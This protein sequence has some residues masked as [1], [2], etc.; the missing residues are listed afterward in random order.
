MSG[1]Q[2]PL[3]GTQRRPFVVARAGQALRPGIVHDPSDAKTALQGNPAHFR[4]CSSGVKSASITPCRC[5]P[6]PLV[7]LALPA[8]CARPRG[9]DVVE[10][11]QYPAR[12]LPEIFLPG[13]G[14]IVHLHLRRSHRHWLLPGCIF[15]KPPTLGPSPYASTSGG[16]RFIPGHDQAVPHFWHFS[17][18][19]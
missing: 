6:S 11:P 10:A 16:C 7:N 3:S 9:A 13:A 15:Q 2:A 4:A 12:S 8:P 17:A 1:T 14:D 18:V 5:I 19:H